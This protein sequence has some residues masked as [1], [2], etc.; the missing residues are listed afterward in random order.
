MICYRDMTFCMYK[1]CDK[2]V[3]CFRSLTDS[4]ERAAEHVGLPISS[5]SEK[6]PCYEEKGNSE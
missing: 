5:F 3:G 2:F 6:P 4:V 1:T